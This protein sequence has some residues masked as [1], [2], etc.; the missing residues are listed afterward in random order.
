MDIADLRRQLARA[1]AR[2]AE[3]QLVVVFGSVATSRAR[4][5]SDIDVGVLG[6]GFWEQLEAGTEVG[7]VSGREA[8][9]VD[10]AAASDRLRFEVARDGV[11]VHE[12]EPGAWARFQAEAAIRYFDLA[13]LIALC[14]EGVRRRLLR[15]A[16]ARA[17]G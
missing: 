6:G 5:D 4:P 16:E 11:L 7:R 1:P 8:Q 3:L 14:T 2:W 12:R 17:G 10:L 9:V 15:E 13:P